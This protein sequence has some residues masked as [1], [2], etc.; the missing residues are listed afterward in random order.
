MQHNH[1]VPYQQEP[2]PSRMLSSA[3]EMGPTNSMSSPALVLRADLRTVPLIA[4]LDHVLEVMLK[5]L[6]SAAMKVLY[7]TNALHYPSSHVTIG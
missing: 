6:G 1:V 5:M 7:P 4:T 3:R 2:L